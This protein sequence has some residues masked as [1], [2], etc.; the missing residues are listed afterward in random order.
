[1]PLLSHLDVLPSTY[2][3]SF[4][5]QALS[6]CLFTFLLFSWSFTVFPQY[7]LYKTCHNPLFS[8]FVLFMR[9]WILSLFIIY[10]YFT[11]TIYFVY[12]LLNWLMYRN[13]KYI[14]HEIAKLPLAMQL[15]SPHSLLK[16]VFIYTNNKFKWDVC[17]KALYEISSKLQ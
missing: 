7:T 16:E 6:I 2:L 12:I 17:S 11:F 9:Y 13:N 3:Q 14:L 1:M 5:H 4:C 15:T 10:V 8:T